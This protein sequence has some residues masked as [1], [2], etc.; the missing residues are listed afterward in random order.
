MQMQ[1][2]AEADLCLL[3]ISGTKQERFGE[4]RLPHLTGDEKWGVNDQ[5]QN[6]KGEGF[7]QDFLQDLKSGGA[8]GTRSAC[9]WSPTAHPQ[10]CW[11][12]AGFPPGDVMLMKRTEPASKSL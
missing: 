4:T 8:E 6:T 3:E 10:P 2:L 11:S 9:C 7:D 1:T 5:T 12:S